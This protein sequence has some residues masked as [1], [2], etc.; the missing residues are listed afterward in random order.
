MSAALAAKTVSRWGTTDTNE[1]PVMTSRMKLMVELTKQM[2]DSSLSLGTSIFER[3]IE[4]DRSLPFA[5]RKKAMIILDKLVEAHVEL[6]RQ[7]MDIM[8]DIATGKDEPSIPRLSAMQSYCADCNATFIAVD[9]MVEEI[10]KSRE[11]H[12]VAM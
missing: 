5:I 1:M 6:N 10:T 2:C 3:W 11:N 7:Y 8:N 9:N 4:I 12:A